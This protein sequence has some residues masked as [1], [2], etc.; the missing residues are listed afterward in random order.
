M[1]TTPSSAATDTQWAR[2]GSLEELRGKGV[3]VVHGGGRPIA[4]FMAD[5][6]VFAVDN[7]CPHMGFPLHKGTVRDGMLTCEWHQARF[8][9]RS[10]CTFDLWADDVPSYDTRV[11]DGVVFVRTTP[12][13]TL[14][15]EH[16]VYRLRRGMQ[17]NIGLIQ[18]KSLIGLLQGDV[19]FS[20]IVREMALFGA[21]HQDGF[22]GMTDLTI[23]ANLRPFLSEQ[24]I[25]FALAR[26]G[27]R[28]AGSAANTA[29][30][31]ERQGL[32]G[33]DYPPAQ[34][35]EWMRHWVRSRHRD[36]TERVLLTAIDNGWGVARVADLFAQA[37]TDRVYPN[38]GHDLDA[39]NKAFELLDVIGQEHAREVLPRV[40]AQVV[41]SRGAEED[42]H[43]HHPVEIIEPLRAAE[44]EIP[45]MLERGRGKAYRDEG[46]LL[47]TLLGDDAPA[48]IRAL[49]EAMGGGAA[50]VV[51]ARLVAYAAFVRLARFATSNDVSDWFNPQH[52]V[53]YTNAVLRM[54]ERIG[55]TDQPGIVR[56]VYH[57]ALAIYM[58][59]FLNVPPARMPGEREGL[60]DLPTGAEEL[61]QAFLDALDQRHQV[62][63]A[64][65][66]V[67]RYLRLGHPFGPLVDTLTYATVR[68]DLDF[69]TLQVL[70]AGV[71]QCVRWRDGREAEDRIE[72]ILVGVV[73]SLAAACPTRR[74][75]L[76]TATTAL[77]LHRGEKIHESE[78]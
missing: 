65:R 26:A 52:T 20:E 21:R 53:N 16:F 61:R 30:P 32:A 50:P 7:R 39:T 71:Q 8:D 47:G 59:R 29:R 1:A 49:N 75:A 13:E 18:A 78:D 56:G 48:I 67:V 34:L 27:A 36:G 63:A 15:R 37:L 22:G 69:H 43:W 76:Q 4:V 31:R 23:V 64:A 57:G 60:D 42:A 25:Y 28:I 9:L 51:L 73:R 2:V 35:V 66:I 11:D 19:E 14:T 46:A 54:A 33:E 70:E 24:T 72:H 68:E 44:R 3:R 55:D 10:G 41:G 17:Q 38:L 5:E 62:D 74:G 58:D 6:Q 40:L 12:R 77:R 45:R